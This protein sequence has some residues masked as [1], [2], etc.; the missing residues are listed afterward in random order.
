[1]L[2]EGEDGEVNRQ[3]V[4]VGVDGSA[5]SFTALRW[6][7]ACRRRTDVMLR[8]VRC[9]TPVLTRGCEAA[10]AAQPM[11]TLAEQQAHARHQLAQ[12]VAA[13]LIEVPR[14]SGR[15]VVQQRVVCSPAGPGLVSQAAMADLLVI[16]NGQQ[17]SEALHQ[18]VRWYCIQHAHCPVLLFPPAMATR[19]APSPVLAGVPA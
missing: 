12:I 15:V 16:G 11:P 5:A 2:L 6:V 17:A 13:V 9:W 3:S 18:S 8:A 7:L 1:M 19:R 4:V 14:S 10:V